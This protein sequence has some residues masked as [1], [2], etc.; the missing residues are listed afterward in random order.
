MTTPDGRTGTQSIERAL[1]VLTE[2]TA[3]SRFGWRPTD[4]AARCGLDR[5][6]T[7]R[8][9][10]CLVRT[11]L[12]RQRAGDRHYVPGPLLFEMG[13]AL[14]SYPEFQAQ[15]HPVLARVARGFGGYALLCVRSGMD[16]VCVATAGAPAYLGTAFDVGAR[17]PLTANAAGV[18]ILVALPRDRARAIVAATLRV[19][20]VPDEAQRAA[21][22]RLWQRSVAA[23]YG[24]NQGITAR[25]VNAVGVPVADASGTAFGSLALAGS[26]AKLPAA[27]TAE[28]VA[29][30]RMEAQAIERIARRVL[31]EGTYADAAAVAGGVP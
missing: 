3:R 15:A 20:E 6:T 25:G 10:A 21:L 1:L 27:R 26:A 23:G 24:T 31:P 17:R 11:G 8:I 4:L 7:H 12:V 2:I 9:L 29:A 30:L 22:R 5:G 28:V 14:P 19:S 18:A 16:V 13:I